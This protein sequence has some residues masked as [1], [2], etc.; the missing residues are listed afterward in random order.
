LVSAKAEYEKQSKE[1][2]RLEA[3]L[4]QKLESAHVATRQTETA[5]QYT[6]ARAA[7]L[8]QELAGL[9]QVREELNSK[10]AKEQQVSVESG[11][12]VQEL[13]NHLSQRTADLERAK[14]DYE[15]QSKD[16][17]RLEADLRQRLESAHAATRQTETAH[18][19][20]QARAAQLE[21]EL[22]G[23]RHAR[24]ELNS[25][26]AREQ[27]VSAES[28]NRVKELETH[29][30]QRTTDLERVREELDKQSQTHKRVHA[31]LN[32]QLDTKGAAHTRAQSRIAELEQELAGLRQTG[33]ELNSKFTREQ[34]L[35]AES[36]NRI[37]ELENILS[38]RAADLER[39][40]AELEKQTESHQRVHSDLT[41]KLDSAAAAHTRA[42]SRVA[43]LE[44]ELT[45]LRQ[46]GE[47]LNSKFTKEQQVSAESGSRVKELENTLSQRAS[48]WERAKADL[49]KETEAHKRTQT[50]LSGQLNAACA[51]HVR[52]QSRVAQLEQEIVGLRQASDELN[53]KVT[54][55]QQVSTASG[56]RVKELETT[57]TQRTTELEG[58]R[59]ELQ[60]HAETHRRTQ[61]ESTAK[62]D[63][64]D[65][66]QTRAQARVTQL[67]Q[68]L[69]GLRQTGE[70]LNCK[71]A[72]EQQFSAETGNRVKELESILSQRAADWERARAEL[73]KQA[74]AHRR[75]HS[76]LSA[77][78][79]TDAAAHTTAQSRVAQLEPELT[80]LRQSHQELNAKFAKEQ[81]RATELQALNKQLERELQS[82]KAALEAQTAELERQVTYGVASLAR[83]TADLAKETGAR[84][85]SDERVAAL[86]LRLQEMHAETGRLLQ[87]QRADHE[88]IGNLETLLRQRDE[89]IARST[90]DL[91]QKNAEC[92]LARN[93][94]QQAKELN[95]HLRKNSAL[96]EKA[97]QTLN[98]AH[99]HLHSR[100]QAS[101]ESLQ[102]SDSTLQRET[103]E[104]QRLATALDG[105]QRDLQAQ[106][107]KRETLGTELQSALQAVREVESKLQQEAAERQRLATTLETVQRD[108]RYQS[109]KREM[110]EAELQNAIQALRENQ[111]RADQE[112]AERQRLAQ[113]L[114][115]AQVD[116]RARSQRA[117][118]ELS[119][120]QSA[121]EFEQVQ[122]KQHEAQMARMR[123]ITL[124]SARGAR[125]LR[126]TLRRQT[127]EPVESLYQSARTLLQF[128]LGNDQKKLAEAI[129]QDALMVQA[130]LQE[131]ERPQVDSSQAS[132]ETDDGLSTEAVAS[133]PD[134]SQQDQSN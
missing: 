16:R 35:S 43:Q 11:H 24:E 127:R 19:Q 90:T 81:N 89:T 61:S 58:A 76:D 39:A 34:Q 86:N 4:H 56:N 128:D 51:A 111:S 85:R 94:F 27:Q 100:L 126:N 7:Q 73:E 26:F 10:F 57:L 117:D 20:A 104:R 38:Q 60:R 91:E 48:D 72:K 18:H 17:D 109:Q 110:V 88:R 63:A 53:W 22:A 131:L 125:A 106:G 123:H 44:R 119:K 112:T 70:E 67:E 132:G 92:L 130:R 25:K 13:E 29:L 37:K 5:H 54:K 122:R 114:D 23:L 45:G 1:R 42:Q 82:E 105:A 120:L 41:E 40:K 107:R 69:A 8:E 87:A 46:V 121:L 97:H 71:F 124:D 66:A 129:L 33:N 21:Q 62:L 103:A 14:A 31:D 49:E 2:D 65:A 108:L 99:H 77:Q 96:V 15:K 133:V 93:Q 6:Q 64:A 47:E 28:A 52:A 134:A 98:N 55:E 79:D 74:E 113:A 84:Q 118:L 78:L 101:L 30:S 80:Q 9:R 36:A 116:L 12:R 59:A 3:D 95:V 68:E 50:D 102:Q 32:T 75:A 115:S 83:V